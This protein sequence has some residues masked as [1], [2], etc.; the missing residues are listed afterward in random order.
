MST[1]EDDPPATAADRLRATQERIISL[2][3]SACERRSLLQGRETH[4]VLVDTL[5]VILNQL[6]EALSPHHPRR[7]A[8]QGST[9]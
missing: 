9:A 6:A 4:L 5:P 8:T 7:T 3:K 2:G 1:S